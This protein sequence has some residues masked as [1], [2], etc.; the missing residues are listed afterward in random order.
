MKKRF[1]LIMLGLVLGLIFSGCEK[2]PDSVEHPS[3]EPNELRSMMKTTQPGSV[4]LDMCISFDSETETHIFSLAVYDGKLYAGTYPGGNIYVFDGNTWSLAFDTETESHVWSLAVYENKL[5]AGTEPGG[6]VYEYDG[7]DWSLSFDSPEWHINCLAVYD[8]KLY[9]GTYSEGKIYVYDGTSWSLATDVFTILA[10]P[11]ITYIDYDSHV[12]S[13]AEYNG[14]LYAGAEAH[15][16]SGPY[17]AVI[18]V[19]DGLTW[20][21]AYH[22]DEDQ[23]RCMA[24]YD[25]KLYAGG[26]P[27]GIIYDFD[28]TSWGISFDSPEEM[29]IY[30]LAVHNDNLYAGTAIFGEIYGFDGSQWIAVFDSPEREV[31]SLASYMGNLYAGTS[32]DGRIYGPCK[33]IIDIDIKPGSDPNSINCNNTKGVIP[34]AILTTD[35]FDAT[36]VDHTTVYFG[37]N[38][39]EASET[40]INKKTGEIKRH[41]KDIDG[42]GDIDLILHFRFGD[43]G[44]ECGDKEAILTGETFEGQKIKGIDAIRTVGY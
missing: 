30:S 10:D 1:Y 6:L 8:G 41:E 15:S 44:I 19:Y 32:E 34:V 7:T 9:A 43:T 2:L 13:L 27:A 35:D 25:D 18:L 26:Y 31:L 11:G 4:A 38:G 28:G 12:F 20:S 14:R 39:T 33:T 5:Y 29:V 24:V 42:D 16:A 40:H 22:A 36:V 21:I 37:K 23:I 17:G 3:A